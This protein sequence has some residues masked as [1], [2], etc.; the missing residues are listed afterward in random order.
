MT[1]RAFRHAISLALL[2]TLSLWGGP[3]GCHDDYSAGAFEEAG[4]DLREFVDEYFTAA[5]IPFLPTRSDL[6]KLHLQP[7]ES[8][9][10]RLPDALREGGGNRRYPFRPGLWKVQD[11]GSGIWQYH[12]LVREPQRLAQTEAF[13]TWND[14]LGEPFADYDDDAYGMTLLPEA[15]RREVEG[16]YITFDVTLY[17]LTGDA[18]GL[19]RTVADVVI[20]DYTPWVRENAQCH[21]PRTKGRP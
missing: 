17:G 13:N 19:P 21:T 20:T 6:T 16:R 7:Q 9:I 5:H 1:R 11:L 8:G 2:G 3:A 12:L 10:Y 18:T 4:D 14:L 15:I